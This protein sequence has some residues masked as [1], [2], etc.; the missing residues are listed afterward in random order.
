ML[1]SRHLGDNRADDVGAEAATGQVGVQAT[2]LAEQRVTPF[3]GGARGVAGASGTAAPRPGGGPG[4]VEFGH[5]LLVEGLLDDPGGTLGSDAAGAQLGDEAAA[6]ARL[7]PDPLADERGGESIVV[8]PA[9]LLQVRQTGVDG[10]GREPLAQQA[11][12]QLG[13]AAGAMGEE[14]QRGLADAP[15]KVTLLESRERGL[16]HFVADAQAGGGHD[17]V[18]RSEAYRAIDLDGDA[19]GP[20]GL[21]REGSDTDTSLLARGPA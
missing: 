6:P 11:A 16:L 17:F 2:P 18:G 1:T 14:V 9:A 7:A 5:V 13:D 3:G 21:R 4:Q 19:S 12:P 15:G 10:A 20:A 8:E